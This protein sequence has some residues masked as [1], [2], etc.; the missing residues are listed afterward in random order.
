MRIRNT[1]GKQEADGA[2]VK[3]AGAATSF[4]GNYNTSLGQFRDQWQRYTGDGIAN[5]AGAT[6]SLQTTAIADVGAHLRAAA[7]FRNGTAAVGTLTGSAA[8]VLGNTLTTAGI[9]SITLVSQT[10]A[11]VQGNAASAASVFSPDGTKVAFFSGA[12]NLLTGDTGAANQILIKDLQTGAIT[13]VSVTAGGAFGNGDSNIGMFSPDGTKFLFQSDA[14]NLVAG[15]TNGATDIF[16]KD[17]TTGA[18]TRVSTF[19][20]GSQSGANGS[21]SGGG[22]DPVFSADGT[23]I[24]FTSNAGLVAGDTN[25]VQDVYVKDLSTG[26]L[27]LASVTSTGVQGDNDSFHGAFSPDG[28]LV[29]FESSATSFPGN[30]NTVVDVFVK[31]LT[32]GAL[33]RI[34]ASANPATSNS[35]LNIFEAFSPDG[36]KI[37]FQSSSNTLVSGDTNNARDL[38]LYDLQTG[39]STLVSSTSSGGFLNALSSG[40]RFSSDGSKVIFST[41]ATNA[42]SGDTNG[43]ADVFEKDLITGTLTLISQTA[44]GTQGNGDSISPTMSPDGSHIVFTSDASNLAPNDINATTDVLVANLG[45][46]AKAAPVAIAA[47]I[48]LSDADSANMASAS[49]TIASGFQSGD[50]LSATTAGTA[51]TASYNAAT[52]VLTLSGSDTVAHYQSVLRS[53]S[54]SNPSNDDPAAS[55]TRTFN[56][57]AND[58]T[59]PSNAATTTI[60]VVDTLSGSAAPVIGGTATTAPVV[61]MALVSTTGTGAQ[62][63]NDNTIDFPVFSRDGTKVA[64]TTIATNLGQDS[65]V[66]VENIYIKDLTTGAI[67]IGSYGFFNLSGNGDSFGES[68]SPDGTK[69]LFVSSASQ[70][71]RSDTNDHADVFIKDL[72]SGAV[73]L[74]ST[75]SNGS[76]FTSTDAV[77]ATFSPDGTKVV[78]TEG[79][80]VYVK[81]LS[82]GA[83]TLASS[84]ST[85]VAGDGSSSGGQLSSDGTKVGFTSNSNSFGSSGTLQV[86][87]KDL[88]TG[89]LTAVTFAGPSSSGASFDGFSPDGT[90]ALVETVISPVNG[91]LSSSIFVVDIAT[92]TQTLV[93]ADASGN[94]GDKTAFNARFSADGSKVVFTSDS[95]NLVAGDTN[96][97]YDIFEKDLNTGA[98]KLVS[99]TA[100]GGQGDLLSFTP[101]ISSDGSKIAFDSYADSLTAGD[102]NSTGDVFVASLG[103][104]A[105]AAPMAIAAGLT[106][107]DADSTA[108]AGAT[109]TISNGFQSGDTLSA[110]TAGTSITASYNAT[111]HVLTL[112]GSDTVAHYQSVLRSVAFSNPTNNDPA[113]SATRTFT[114]VA[115]DGT[116][117][118]AAATTTINVADTATGTHTGNVTITGTVAVGSTLTANTSAL[119]DPNG[120]GTLHYTWTREDGHGTVVG[121]D[122]PTYAPVQAD[123]GFKIFLEVTYTDGHGN[124]ELVTAQTTTTVFANNAP[125]DTNGDGFSDIVW[126]NTNGQAAIWTVNGLTQ[127]GGAQVGGNPGASWHLKASADFDGD[128]KADLLWQNDSGQAAIWTLDGFTQTGGAQVGANPGP[129]WHVKAAADFDGDGKADILWQNDSGQVAIWTMNGLTQIGGATVGGN[130]GPS[131]HVVGTGDFNGDGKADILWQN[132]NGQAAIWLMDG[133]TQIGGAQVGGNPGP[134]WHV[135]AAGDFNGDGKADILW[136]NDS[137]QAAIWTMDG[138]TQTGG[139]TV[140][141][142]PGPSW[143]VVG[144]GDYNGD[145]KAD[146]LWQNDNGQIAIWTMNGF[147]QLGGAQI[148]GTPGTAWHA[149]GG[150]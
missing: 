44:S 37:L 124:A 91:H 66:G 140:G 67:T 30:N 148:G 20:D 6:V 38:F 100:L 51:I 109:V 26:A 47:D 83:I 142:N 145:G 78:F 73:T 138:L 3:F 23:K 14:S 68:F 18:I 43:A 86:Y 35:N 63:N 7:T 150:T 105:K 32:T 89:V 27:T 137:G 97:T 25:G 17:L 41:Y 57:V 33:T 90:K 72:A 128:G 79:T 96:N 144:T 10:A 21:H 22:S 39:T 117:P 118:S 122:Q 54:F 119:A 101:T 108:L 88:T 87:V 31:N 65:A 11:G 147:T 110:A 4:A 139:A 120:L 77:D 123:S 62:G 9:V 92:G 76:Q 61:S 146:I 64:F 5:V 84:S 49:V 69:L 75:D 28:T 34:S 46:L 111:T 60:N 99:Q 2:E 36:T 40:G 52:H 42:V 82:S 50:T 94:S 56:W 8:P 113:A 116:S 29:A 136:Q 125:A 80:Q 13:A 85:G 19:A 112:S 126:Q 133:L 55:A 114:W 70:L 130:P 81:T 45:Y 12:S 93:S 134:T 74:V 149:V 107:S 141:G 95:D 15:D 102:V 127:T 98:I 104:V 16:L 132:D 24:L 1:L 48:T 135:I 143:H 58:G 53:V 121:A 115:N 131:W 71:V 59:S 103:Y 106:L 129:S